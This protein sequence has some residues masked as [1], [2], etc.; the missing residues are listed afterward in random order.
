MAGLA[1]AASRPSG[2]FLLPFYLG[3]IANWFGD[4]FDGAL[5]RH[6]GI[7]R[8]HV[9][10]LI[11]RSG[12]IVSFAIMILALGLSPYLTWNAALMLL[13]AYFL[14]ATYTIPRSMSTSKAKGSSTPSGFPPTGSRRRGLAI[15]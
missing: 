5:A 1:I 9:G 12:D 7:E 10:F 13:F 6:R 8:R 11:D 2:W 15:C 14:H 4:S 3:L